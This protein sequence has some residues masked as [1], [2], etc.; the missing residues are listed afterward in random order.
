MGM[1]PETMVACKNRMGVLP[2]FKPKVIRPVGEKPNLNSSF[3]GTTILK[4]CLNL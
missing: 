1:I 4:Y 3:S 2:V